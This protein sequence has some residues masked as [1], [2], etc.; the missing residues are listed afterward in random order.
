MA[1]KRI[2]KNKKIVLIPISLIII[3]IILFFVA[4]VRP[5]V[6]PNNIVENINL[7][8]GFKIEIYAE[9]LG[10]SSF[11]TPGP[12]AGPRFMKFV[13]DSD[14]LFV[15]LMRQGK[16]V[17]ITDTGETI[18]FMENLN[19]PHGIDTYEDWFY[20]AEENRV[21]RVKDSDEDLRADR[22]V[23]VL[24]NDL[25]SGGHFTRT[26]KIFNESLYLSIGSSCNVCFESDERRAAILKCNLDGSDCKVFAKGLRNSVGFIFHPDTNEIYATDNERDWLGEDLPPD[27]INLVEEGKDYGWPICYGKRN[28]DSD[29]DDVVYIR[30]P[31]EDTEAPLV[32]LQAHSAPLGLVIY[33]DTMFPKEYFGDLFVAY[34]GSW[35]RNEPTG[36][37]IVRIDLVTFEVEDFATGW[38]QGNNVLGRPVDIVIG[39]DGSMYVSDDNAGVIYRIFYDN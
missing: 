35:N 10:G 19:K 23:E 17:G 30:N 31:C 32:E 25:P 1:K 15:T 27:E 3:I 33:D 28:H 13:P 4:G 38:L 18:T 34:H 36:Y 21:I 8:D 6:K 11:S 20:I 12:G 7:P 37:K 26:I 16:V 5:S 14:V 24:I 22:E 2:L 39:E 29:F 9:N